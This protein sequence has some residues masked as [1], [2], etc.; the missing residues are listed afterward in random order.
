MENLVALP[1]INKIGSN[2]HQKETEKISLP[3]RAFNV[4]INH[5]NL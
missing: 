3:L 4:F 2:W 5:L 1:K